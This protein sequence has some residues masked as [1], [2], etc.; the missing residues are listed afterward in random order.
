MKLSGWAKA[1]VVILAIVISV[2]AAFTSAASARGHDGI[3][4]SRG[5]AIANGSGFAAG[6][7][8]SNDAYVKAASQERDRLL[9]K[10]KDICRGC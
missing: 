2:G 7:R 8:H 9:K 4:S 1:L 10:L 5:G 6:R 3:R